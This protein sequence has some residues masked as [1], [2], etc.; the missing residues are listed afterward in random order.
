MREPWQRAFA[1]ILEHPEK[2]KPRPGFGQSTG[3]KSGLTQVLSKNGAVGPKKT[4]IEP[5]GP[6][7][8]KSDHLAF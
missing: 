2:S 5:P 7:G 6:P 3:A 4:S 1:P 8:G